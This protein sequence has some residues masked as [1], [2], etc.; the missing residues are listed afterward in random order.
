M[1]IGPIGRAVTA[2]AGLASVVLA[3]LWRA[4]SGYALATGCA[5]AVMVVAAMVDAVEHR[6][7]NAVVACAGVPVAIGGAV[8]FM[9]DD[10]A[11]VSMLLGSAYLALPLLVTHLVSPAGMGFGDV[12]AG[13]VLGGAL[14]LIDDDFALPVLIVALAIVGGWGLLRGRRSMPLGPGLVAGTISVLAVAWVVGS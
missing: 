13:I 14:G 2:V 11:W 10:P 8:A 6:L 7:P 4:G 12:K 3:G 1:A 9:L 5:L